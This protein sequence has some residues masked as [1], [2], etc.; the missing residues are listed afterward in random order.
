MRLP[1]ETPVA[2]EVIAGAVIRC[3]AKVQNPVFSDMIAAAEHCKKSVD[4]LDNTAPLEKCI[5]EWIKQRG[6]PLK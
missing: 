6:L 3:F 1:Q 5:D 2:F 4:D